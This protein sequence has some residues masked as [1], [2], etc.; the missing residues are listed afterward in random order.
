MSAAGIGPL[1]FLRTNVTAAS[2]QEV[3]EHF[4]LSTAEKLFRGDE[5]IFQHNLAPTQNA[6][7]IKTWFTMYGMQVLSWPANSPGLN[8]IENLWR[9]A[10]KRMAA[11]LEQLK[12]SMKQAWSSITLA[13]CQRLVESMPR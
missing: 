9:I 12:V 1:C 4:L 10:K 6:K 3:L 13:N 11:T 8:P 5:F 7:S 2:H